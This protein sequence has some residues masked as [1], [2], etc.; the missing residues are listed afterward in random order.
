MKQC[1]HVLSTLMCL[2][3]TVVGVQAQTP[4]A[5]YSFTGNANDQTTFG[6]NAVVNG[7]TL[8]QDR[9]GFANRAFAFDGVQ[10]GIRANN[11]TQLNSGNLTISFW[12][13][14]KA[15]P[16]QGEVYLMSN[17]GWQERWKIS[18][19][20]HGKPVFTTNASGGIKDMDTDSVSL[21]V[22]AWTQVVMVHDSI[23]GTNK[24]YI[25]GV[26]KKSIAATGALNKTTK[27]L[28]IGYDPIDTTNYF[29][30]SLDEVTLYNIALTDVQIAALYAAQ[31][32]IPSVSNARVAAY[33]FNGSGLDSSAFANHAALTNVKE[34]TD[35]FGFGAKALW[36]IGLGAK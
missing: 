22:G 9:F 32:A 15:L 35:R 31:N 11:A 1:L 16:A 29:N 27:P 12:V 18:L 28:G 34:T 36:V 13:K 21:A 6:N 7:A 4:V 26:L 25:N 17:G 20:S 30:G 19:P 14:V 3:L 8:T 24:A 10:S 23:S 2:L 33:S 5:Q